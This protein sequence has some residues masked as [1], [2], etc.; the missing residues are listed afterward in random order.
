MG[1]GRAEVGAS[2]DDAL[3]L[4]PHPGSWLPGSS[5]MSET[6]SGPSSRTRGGVG[7]CPVSGFLESL[8]GTG[9]LGDLKHANSQNLAQGAALAIVTISP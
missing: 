3:R 4:L 9:N 2:S 8:L 6:T 5:R 1:T 7:R